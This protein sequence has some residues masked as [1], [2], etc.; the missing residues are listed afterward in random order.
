[1]LELFTRASSFTLPRVSLTLT[2]MLG[3][4]KRK[5]ATIVSQAGATLSGRSS[6][7][8]KQKVAPLLISLTSVCNV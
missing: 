1:M 5:A 4:R 6:T 8:L 3:L 7:K 2:N